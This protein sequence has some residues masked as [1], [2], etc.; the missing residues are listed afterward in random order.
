MLMSKVS[1]S[2]RQ[3][4]IADSNSRHRAEVSG[5]LFSSY[6]IIE[7]R[8]YSQALAGILRCP[9]DLLLVGEKL[10]PGGGLDLV[11][12]LR[13]H[14]H[15][16][17]LPIIF[18]CSQDN[19]E[20]IELVLRCG[21]TTHLLKPY[22]RS[23][24]LSIISGLVNFEV[25]QHWESLPA[26]QRTALR[27]TID[28]FNSISDVIDQGE[29]IA[30]AS[31]AA[32]CQPVVDA[33]AKNDFKSILHGVRD[34]DNY[35][36]AHSLRVATLLSLFGYTIG[37]PESEQIVLTSGGLLHDVGKMS[38]PQEVL[39]KPGALTPSEWEV[40]KSHV[41]HSVRYLKATSGIPLAILTI[42]EQHHEKLDG[43]GYPHQLT[44]TQLNELARMA[45]IVDVFSALTDRRAYKPPMAAEEALRIMNCGMTGHLDENLLHLFGQ[46]LLDAMVDNVE[47]DLTALAPSQV[48]DYGTIGAVTAVEPGVDRLRPGDQV[49]AM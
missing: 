14:P 13:Q 26:L 43:T 18:I 17:R 7:Y 42:A 40:M 24:L 41:A 12:R 6:R 15:L 22:R 49:A 38:I 21:A 48:P 8:N 2:C 27:G 5:A 29:P 1:G 33:V 36:Y 10:S 9:P 4:A 37:L 34:H 19:P 47:S 11:E 3:I 35:S 30:F 45:S 23:A 44:S 16:K 46:M 25:E 20:P 39:N 31:V 32:A 28:V